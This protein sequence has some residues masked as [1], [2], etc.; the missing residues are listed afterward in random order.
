MAPRSGRHRTINLREP[1]VSPARSHSGCARVS[2]QWSQVAGRIRGGVGKKAR[3][4]SCRRQE[5]GRRHCS[6]EPPGPKDKK[7]RV[8]LHTVIRWRGCGCGTQALFGSVCPLPK[9]RDGCR[10]CGNHFGHL[11]LAKLMRKD[12][13]DQVGVVTVCTGCSQG[14]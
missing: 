12:C 10:R 11:A 2:V 6:L 5:K 7:G 9:P 13:L 14:G 1:G 3:N 4:P 8:L